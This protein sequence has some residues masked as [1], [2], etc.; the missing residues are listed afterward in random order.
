MDDLEALPRDLTGAVVLGGG[1]GDLGGDLR[2]PLVGQ[3]GYRELVVGG[4]PRVRSCGQSRLGG[5]GVVSGDELGV[6][7]AEVF[8][9][10]SPRAAGRLAVRQLG[11]DERQDELAVLSMSAM[12]SYPRIDTMLAPASM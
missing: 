4:A 8:A 2:Q 6:G 5:G 3:V 11:A 10:Q 7:V 1:L 12:P 9:L